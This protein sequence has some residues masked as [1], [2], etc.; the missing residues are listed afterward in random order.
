MKRSL[1]R[2]SGSTLKT[3]ILYLLRLSQSKSA[4]SVKDSNGSVGQMHH[5][6]LLQLIGTKLGVSPEAIVDFELCLY[7][8]QPASLGGLSDEFIHASRI[9]NLGMSFMAL[10]GLISEQAQSTLDSDTQIRVVALFDNE[11]VGSV[12]AHGAA[13][14]MLEATLRRLAEQVGQSGSGSGDTVSLCPA[15]FLCRVARSVG[16]NRSVLHLAA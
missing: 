13:S 9:D 8:A 3:S 14:N 7:D 16:A 15:S 12:S 11:E 5:P 2:S 6:E 4:S 1:S 10:E